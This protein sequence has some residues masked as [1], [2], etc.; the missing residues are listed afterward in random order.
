MSGTPKTAETAQPT[1]CCSLQGLLIVGGGGHGRVV[2]EAAFLSRRFSR[3]LVIDPNAAA[4][5]TFSL[6]PCVSSE[7]N[8]DARPTDWQFI[9]A[10]GEPALRQRLFDEFVGKGFDPASVFH[11]AAIISPSALIGRGVAVLGGAVVATLARI[12]DGVIVNHNAVVEHE[13]EVAAFAHVAPGA[14]LAGGAKLGE[15]SFLGSNSSVRHGKSVGSCI[16]IGNGTAVVTDICE[17]GIYGGTPARMLKK[18]TMP[19]EG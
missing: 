2:A 5:W 9:S 8:A 10:V 15:K 1:D 12:G 18:I 16:V 13:S 4:G 14:V 7:V 3:L 17:P 6:C 19:K 11:P